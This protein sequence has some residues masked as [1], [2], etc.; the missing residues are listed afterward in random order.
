[1]AQQSTAV[2]TTQ[3]ADLALMKQSIVDIVGGKLNSYMTHGEIA[4]PKDYSPANAMRFAWLA[5]QDVTNKDGRPALEVC[6]KDSI[7]NALLSMAV[8]ALNVGKNQGYF[9]VYGNKLSFQR[10]YFG[11]MAVTKM[12]EP[13][14]NDF[15]Y[16]V[17]YQGDVFR[18][19]IHL[20]K[21]MVTEHEQDIDNVDKTKIKAAYCIALDKTGAPYRTE[22]MTIDQIHQSWKQSKMN[23]FD[24]HGK[25]KPGST[26]AKFT[27]DMCL[28]TVVNKCCKPI[29]NTSTDSQLLLD[30]VRRTEDVADMAVVDEEIGE[31]ANQ[32]PVIDVTA[33]TTAVGPGEITGGEEKA[34]PNPP[35]PSNG[36]ASDAGDPV[37][38]FRTMM[39]D[40]RTFPEL[41]EVVRLVKESDL[42]AEDKKMLTNDDYKAAAK[43]IK[44]GPAPETQAEPEPE[45]E[46]ATGTDG[47]G[48]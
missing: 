15:A 2:A 14:V 35:D 34:E 23:P 12:V 7:A 30:I 46:E 36:A 5:L 22:I 31:R 8:Q 42:S 38:R 6:T 27:E 4:L 20:G 37:A 32:G 47:P 24:E 29:I 1:M 48:W 13:K 40:T 11:T 39:S 3:S 45:R 33:G 21:K 19:G 28:R 9:I 41:N 25:L 18:Y 10:S 43:R 16:A 26:H 17:V 44:A